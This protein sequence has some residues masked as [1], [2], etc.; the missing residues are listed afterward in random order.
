[1]MKKSTGL[2]R[3]LAFSFAILL[4]GMVTAGAQENAET[5]GSSGQA[6]KTVTSTERIDWQVMSN[7][8]MV[9]GSSPDYIHMGTI[10]QSATGFGAGGSFTMGHGFWLG[11]EGN[12]SCCEVPGDANNDGATNVGDAV[13]VISYVF[14]GGA[15]PFCIA[16]GDANDD[17]AIN[18]AD[19][20][21]LAR[22]TLSKGT[23]PSCGCSEE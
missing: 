7:G 22:Y 11:Y 21:F 9:A 14:R 16:E 23:A 5:D 20:V 15:A 13:F 4:A 3:T 10:G 18:I 8:G 17:C 19:A 2:Y 1:M 12:D 6:V